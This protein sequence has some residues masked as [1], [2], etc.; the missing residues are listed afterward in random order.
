MPSKGR[1]HLKQRRRHRQWRK[2]RDSLPRRSD[3]KGHMTGEVMGMRYSVPRPPASSPPAADELQVVWHNKDRDA[4]CGVCGVR[5]HHKLCRG[6]QTVILFCSK[7]RC[8]EEARR[9]AVEA[10]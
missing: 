3:S 8:E 7:K 4:I 9:R 1:A 5:A 2:W 6:K 10:A